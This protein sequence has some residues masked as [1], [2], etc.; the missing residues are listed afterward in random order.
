MRISGTVSTN[1][2]VFG[3]CFRLLAVVAVLASTGN[4]QG[5]QKTASQSPE[6][7]GEYVLSTAS[8]QELPAVVSENGSIRQEVIG[9]SVKLEADG[10]FVWQTLYRYSDR[11]SSSESQSTGRGTYS[12]RATSIILSFDGDTSLGEGTLDGDTLTIRADVPMVY[13]KAGGDRASQGSTQPVTVSP[14]TGRVPPPPP[15]PRAGFTSGLSLALGDVPGS[16]EELCHSSVLIV[17][18]HVQSI[19]AP[20]ENL[21]YLET[22]AILSV[23]R[24]LKGMESIRQVV[25][26]QKGGVLGQYR[27]LPYQYNLMQQ[28]EHYILFLTEETETHLPDFAGIPRY[29]LTGSWTGMFKIDE[30]G[31]HLSPD[32]ADLIFE[33]F[34]GRP[35]HDV[36]AEIQQ[37]PPTKDLD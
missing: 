31:V 29:A 27:Q 30:S 10:T 37:C 7:V 14:G 28:A 35:S 23:D 32:T 5:S 22:D 16:F 17:E 36:I 1:S 3:I 33:R 15:P 21:R 20:T 25:I 13:R 6:A 12:Q 19:L 2:D 9:G 8:G 18:A 26:S 11:G 34:D 24:V 4:V